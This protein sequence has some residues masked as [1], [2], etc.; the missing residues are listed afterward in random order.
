MEIMKTY[1]FNT[2]KTFITFNHDIC[3]QKT[4]S[5]AHTVPGSFPYTGISVLFQLIAIHSC[6]TKELEVG[7]GKELGL[8]NVQKINCPL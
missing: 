5:L 3:N 6:S 2:H 8:H 7:M 1:C 4:L